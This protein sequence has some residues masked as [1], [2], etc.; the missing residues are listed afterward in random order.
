MPWQ[1]AVFWGDPGLSPCAFWGMPGSAC[2]F[3]GDPGLGVACL[4]P[5]EDVQRAGQLLSRRAG[6][7]V[8]SSPPPSD[9][10][11]LGAAFAGVGLGCEKQPWCWPGR[12]HECPAAA[13]DTRATLSEA[14]GEGGAAGAGST[15]HLLLPARLGLCSPLPAWT[16]AEDVSVLRCRQWLQSLPT[17]GEEHGLAGGMADKRVALSV[18]HGWAQDFH[19]ETCRPERQARWGCVSPGNLEPP[20]MERRHAGSAC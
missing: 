16:A 11:T 18:P 6:H 14:L 13:R 2:A 20:G 10:I 3:W 17:P 5:L 12:L 7:W 19:G 8:V 4:V 9:S 15:G 1:H